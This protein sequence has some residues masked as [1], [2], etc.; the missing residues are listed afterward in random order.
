MIDL[1]GKIERASEE[2]KL[3]EEKNAFGRPVQ[4]ENGMGG[5][6]WLAWLATIVSRNVQIV[7]PEKTQEL[8]KDQPF[9]E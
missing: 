5:G 4:G 9:C 2:G 6:G 3:K 7:M 1:Q 8:P